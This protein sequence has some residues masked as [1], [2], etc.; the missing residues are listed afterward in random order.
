MYF[1]SG[2]EITFVFYTYSKI[3]SGSDSG[4]I[5]S[6]QTHWHPQVQEKTNKEKQV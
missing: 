5:S 2:D 6:I 1:F 4:K 3:M